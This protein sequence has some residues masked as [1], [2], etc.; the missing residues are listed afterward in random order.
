ML[1]LLLGGSV[2]RI[3]NLWW[4]QSLSFIWLGNWSPVRLDTMTCPKWQSQSQEEGTSLEQGHWYRSSLPPF[5]LSLTCTSLLLL[6]SQ[7]VKSQPQLG[8]VCFQ[9]RQVLRS[10]N[11]LVNHSKQSPQ[12]HSP[13]VSSMGCGIC[14][15]LQRNLDDPACETK[16]L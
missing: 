13:V 7:R 6:L 9:G 12:A 5:L 11:C 2:N 10:Y 8:K 14:Q 15:Q 16:P 3:I 4:P 1:G